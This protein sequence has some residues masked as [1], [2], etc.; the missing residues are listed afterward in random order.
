MCSQTKIPVRRLKRLPR[1]RKGSAPVGFRP[2][3]HT[4]SNQQGRKSY[5]IAYEAVHW[6]ASENR[7]QNWWRDPQQVLG[8]HDIC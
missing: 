7:P 2:Q 3:G 5:F 6:K 8:R 1:G 4:Y